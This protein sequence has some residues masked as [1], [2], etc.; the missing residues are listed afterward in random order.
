VNC[1]F[2]LCERRP[3][4]IGRLFVFQMCWWYTARMDTILERVSKLSHDLRNSLSVVYSHAQLLELLL[5]GKGNK[6]AH[7]TAE[8]L[9][10]SV[11]DT[12]ALLAREIAAL[13]EE[14]SRT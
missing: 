12:E 7:E 6:E 4:P 8:Q 5:Q 2:E 9:L 10:T 11:H 3:I 1:S 13:R 14:L